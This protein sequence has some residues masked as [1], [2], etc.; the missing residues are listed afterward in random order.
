MIPIDP[1]PQDGIHQPLKKGSQ[2]N[3]RQVPKNQQNDLFETL[4][5][6]LSLDPHGSNRK[7]PLSDPTFTDSE[8]DSP[9]TDREA[10]PLSI[11]SLLSLAIEDYGSDGGDLG[12]TGSG[13]TSGDD[14]LGYASPKYV[15]ANQLD[16]V[17]HKL[18]SNDSIKDITPSNQNHLFTTRIFDDGSKLISLNRSV[19]DGKP[20]NIIGRGEEGK[21]RLGYFIHADGNEAL[22]AIKK[23]AN[24]YD[25]Q[26]ILNSIELQK[27]CASPAV[28]KPLKVFLSEKKKEMETLQVVMPLAATNLNNKTSQSIYRPRLFSHIIPQLL[29]GLA[30]IHHNDI[31]F[32][33]LDK[34]NILALSKNTIGYSDFG[35]A[36]QNTA[37]SPIPFK[38]KD[39]VFNHLK[40]NTTSNEGDFASKATDVFS[41]GI[42]MY[43]LIFDLPTSYTFIDIDT[44]K[45]MLKGA[46]QMQTKGPIDFS[47]Y[48]Q[49]TDFH[50]SETTFTNLKDL[51]TIHGPDKILSLI[52]FLDHLVA[53]DALSRKDAASA[54]ELFNRTFPNETEPNY[55]HGDFSV[56][57]PHDQAKLDDTKKQ[58]LI[59]QIALLNNDDIQWV[60]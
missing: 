4:R 20:Y 14:D 32:R 29:D 39:N 30:N 59:S 16:T 47:A 11:S 7:S 35:A 57:S 1:T 31:I 26:R 9:V 15:K 41:L 23:H 43:E 5:I 52:D 42:V 53:P 48:Q 38:G 45:E 13:Y 21:V 3:A 24:P 8:R 19:K 2:S 34:T 6:S 25:F 60:R 12:S 27:K 49:S 22:V 54:L 51:L 17:T 33:D 28:I 46:I 50:L 36:I 55:D 18:K 40:T 37:D 44:F 58:L 56:F 10:S